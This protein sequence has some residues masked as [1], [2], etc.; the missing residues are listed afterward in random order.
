VKENQIMDEVH[1]KIHFQHSWWRILLIVFAIVA[2]IIACVFNGLASGGPNGMNCF[3]EL[4]SQNESF[5]LLLLLLFHKMI[6]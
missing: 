6:I 2:F 1:S 5:R 3:N 4:I